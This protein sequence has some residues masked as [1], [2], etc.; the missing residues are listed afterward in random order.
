MVSDWQI[1]D[2]IQNRWEI[3]DIK[4]G[5]M[6]VVYIVYDHE[7]HEAFAAKTFQDEVFTRNP[8]IADRFTQEALAWVNLDIH[9]NVTQ[10]R[11]LEVIK[12]KPFLFLEY[13]SGGDLS[14]WIGTPRLTQDLPQVLRFAIQFCDGMIHALSKGIRAHRDIKPQN[15]LVTEDV[16]LK[17]TD[18]GLVKV[19]AIQEGAQGG[20][21]T[22]EYMSPEQW[23]NFEQADERSDIYSFGAMLYEMLTR[24]PP[25]GKRPEVIVRELEQRHKKESSP[26]LNAE[27]SALNS[28][29]QTCL[30]KDPVRRFADLKKVRERLV[31]IYITLMGEPAPQPVSGTK[32]DAAQWHNKG[33]SLGNLRRYEDA[34]ACY[35]RALE[36]GWGIP[37]QRKRPGYARNSWKGLVHF[38]RA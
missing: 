1:G 33:L 29:V 11:F 13:V 14:G 15:C 31:E 22:P 21:G 8:A 12:G 32:L 10:A 34:L 23:D 17:V 27:F 38:Y 7:W 4:R 28:I 19:A 20:M 25:F 35:E 37:R 30:A 18:F 5:G 24:Q 9:Q 2:K 16:T 6:G 3:Y 26:C 36:T